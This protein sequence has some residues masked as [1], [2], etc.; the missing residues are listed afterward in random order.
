VTDRG[1]FNPDPLGGRGV[2]LC[3]AAQQVSVYLFPTEQEREAASARIDPNDPSTLGTAMV[4]W[5]GNPR[6]WQRGRII[7]L[8]LGDAAA[9]EAG[10]TSILGQPFARGH[11]RAPAPDRN[12][13]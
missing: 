6:F 7:V 9:V 3:V 1:A 10:I 11:G 2:R 4:E 12:A 8:Y 5:A 13:C